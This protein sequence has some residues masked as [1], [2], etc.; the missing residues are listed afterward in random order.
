MI[1]EYYIEIIIFIIFIS[2]IAIYLLTRKN[3]STKPIQ[4]IELTDSNTFTEDPFDTVDEIIELDIHNEEDEDIILSTQEV[5]KDK[6]TYQDEE[7]NGTEEGTF[8]LENVIPQT[9]EVKHTQP[10]TRRDVPSHQ[11]I[12]KENFKEFTGIKVLVAEDNLINQKV[13]RGLLDNSGIEI[14]MADDGQEVLDILEVNSDFKIIFMDAHMPRVDGF[15]ATRRIRA[16]P[17]YNHIVV[18]ALSGDTAADDIKKMVDAGMEKQLEKPLRMDALYD[19]IYTYTGE[20]D[21]Y[22]DDNFIEII[23]TKHLNGDKG[24][25]ICS[26]DEDF[27]KEILVEF[28][29]DYSDSSQKIL[30]YI[31]NHQYTHAD[32]LLLDIIGIT[33]NIGAENLHK[34][35][36]TFK[37]SLKNSTETELL[38]MHKHY[39]KN[40]QSLIIDIKSYI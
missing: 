25:G 37:D 13:I 31:Q 12:V 27:Y 5:Y 28:V 16:N 18:I 38:D 40:L 29:K 7:L 11:K 34:I 33:A 17:N 15:E 19:A 24:L 1:A 20:E 9:Q 6:D 32:K 2:L 8:G 23:M 21:N 3:S 10:I 22:D 30:L 14:T 36:H 26:E 4:N 39:S 35:T